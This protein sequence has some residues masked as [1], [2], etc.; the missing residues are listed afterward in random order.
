[1]SGIVGIASRADCDA[2]LGVT[3]LCVY[4]GDGVRSRVGQIGIG[5][6][7]ARAHAEELIGRTRENE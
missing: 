4:K 7:H 2:A 5:A 1:M 3:V 6:G